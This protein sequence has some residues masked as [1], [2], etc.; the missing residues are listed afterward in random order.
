ME[1][2][3]LLNDIAKLEG[4]HLSSIRPGADIVIKKIDMDQ[5]KIVVQNSSG[6]IFNRS[7][8]ELQ[9]IWDA[10]ITEPAVRVEEVLR[11]SGSSRNQP[12]TI[13]ANLP[14][15]EWLK[16]TNKKHIAYVE[17]ASHPYGTLKQMS[18]INASKTA[19]AISYG[20]NKSS[21]IIVTS[22]DRLTDDVND[23][24]RRIG[25]VPVAIS[26]H[27]YK[28]DFKEYDLLFV[29]SSAK[30]I[31]IGVYVQLKTR[32]HGIIGKEVILD[33]QKYIIYRV[34]AI[35]VIIENK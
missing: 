11:G 8:I 19:D 31:D 4:L 17:K 9:R 6:K 34:G 30:N 20:D 12:E 24:S 26:E 10:L 22:S 18:S 3:E 13:F 16:I 35:N 29:D 21:T 14:Y 15:V 27:E 32:P 28:F 7:V 2:S 5:G 23:F 1:F 33:S 25:K